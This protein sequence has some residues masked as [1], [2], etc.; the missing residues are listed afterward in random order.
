MTTEVKS[1]LLISNEDY[2]KRYNIILAWSF[3]EST[4]TTN[5]YEPE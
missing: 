3:N 1:G 2:K 5:I 4:K